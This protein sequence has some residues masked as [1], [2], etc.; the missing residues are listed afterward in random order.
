MQIT[1]EYVKY[2]RKWSDL[3]EEKICATC[4]AEARVTS[5]GKI[6]VE[7]TDSIGINRIDYT[8][9]IFASKDRP[10]RFSLSGGRIDRYIHS[11]SGWRVSKKDVYMIAAMPKKEVKE[12]DIKEYQIVV[13]VKAKS[14]TGA[15]SIIKKYCPD[16]VTIN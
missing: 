14:I 9:S 10:M 15:K 1:L 3:K 5:G 2:P 6:I 13:T 8:G 4:L 7:Q 16:E 12:R 11:S